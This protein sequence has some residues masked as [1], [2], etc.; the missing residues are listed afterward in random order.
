MRLAI[1]SDIHGNLPAL[2]AVLQELQ[3]Y[4]MHG[5]IVAGDFTGGPHPAE[6]LPLLRTL[7]ARMIR[8]NG[9]TYLLRYSNGS[10]PIAW[11]S[12]R[13]FA[14]LR[15]AH[16]HID[17]E[18]LAFLESLPEQR[19]VHLPDTSPIRVVHGSPS[20]SSQSIFP[21]REPDTLDR[22]LAQVSEP[23]L[24]C[25]HTHIPWSLERNGQLALNRGAV[26]G[27]LNGDTRAQFA[28]LTWQD[29]RWRVEHHA[30]PYDLDLIR[31]DFCESGLLEE[32][33]AL[34]RSF[35]LSIETGQNVAESFL[36]YAYRLAADAGFQECDVVPD[37]IWEN[38]ATTFDWGAV[39]SPAA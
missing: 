23:V 28:L 16:Q 14:L 10:A 26:C 24:I 19:T 35:L 8:G 29:H 37:E 17:K 7:A 31:T 4:D 13:Q 27:P 5:I 39:A 9:D 21:D 18:T 30:V 1:M 34:A 22:A 25:G 2:K 20:N 6:T 11:Y 15:W 3:R 33:G 12:S 32:G 38:A 36:A